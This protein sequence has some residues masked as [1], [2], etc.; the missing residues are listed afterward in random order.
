MS[1][2]TYAIK[3]EDGAIRVETEREGEE[4]WSRLEGE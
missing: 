2:G 4:A 1:G 3:A